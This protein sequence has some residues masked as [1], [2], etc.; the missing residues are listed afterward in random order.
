[1]IGRWLSLG[2][3]VSSANKSDR[4]NITEILLKLVLNT[5]KQTNKQTNIFFICHVVLNTYVFYTATS[6]SRYL[7]IPVCP[8]FEKKYN[9]Q[10]D[11]N[12]SAHDTFL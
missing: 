10:V 1:M 8:Q 7:L 4:H 9:K 5:I 6:K 12:Y 11:K 3:P 2:P